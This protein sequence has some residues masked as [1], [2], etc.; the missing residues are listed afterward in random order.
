MPI[1]ELNECS[2]RAIEHAAIEVVQGTL[3]MW[4]IGRRV[5]QRASGGQV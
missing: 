2:T 4:R 5:A 1:L 3:V